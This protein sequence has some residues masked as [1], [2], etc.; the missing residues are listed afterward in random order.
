LFRQLGYAIVAFES[1]YWP[2]ELKDVDV[3][4]APDYATFDRDRAYYAGAGLSAFEGLFLE[5][6]LARAVFDPYLR[7]FRR[8]APGLID[9]EYEKQRIRISVAFPTCQRLGLPPF[10]VCAATPSLLCVWA[11]RSAGPGLSRHGDGC[12]QGNDYVEGYAGQVEFLNRALEIELDE[13]LQ[14]TDG[15]VVIILQGD[16]GPAGFLNWDHPDERGIEERMAILN[17]YRLPQAGAELLYPSITP[18]N[19]FRVVFDGVFGG[20]FGLVQDA[21]HF[22]PWLSLSEAIPVDPSFGE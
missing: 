2:T 10:R 1:G 19:T 17:A 6:T 3:Y 12:C 22:T 20:E 15:D 8:R 4:L 21:G 7:E 11:G 5:S 18:V 14:A 16:H 13:V 9:Y